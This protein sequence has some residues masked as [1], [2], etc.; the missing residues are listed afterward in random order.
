MA[1]VKVGKN[2]VILSAPVVSNAHDTVHEGYRIVPVNSAA[3][4]KVS[5]S[6]E[7]TVV[8][9]PGKLA[10]RSEQAKAITKAGPLTSHQATMA[11]TN[12]TGNMA[13]G[14]S[15]IALD[16]ARP[17]RS[18]S[19]PHS[20]SSFS[21]PR[22]TMSNEQVEQLQQEHVASGVRSIEQMSEYASKI[23]TSCGGIMS[24]MEQ[25]D[26]VRLL[27]YASN[28]CIANFLKMP[29]EYA[30]V[31]ALAVLHLIENGTTA[32]AKVNTTNPDSRFKIKPHEFSGFLSKNVNKLDK[33]LKGKPKNSYCDGSETDC[34]EILN[35][36]AKNTEGTMKLDAKGSDIINSVA[37]L[38][39][40]LALALN[41]DI[42]NLLKIKA[43]IN[44]FRDYRDRIERLANAHQ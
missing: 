8:N 5:T 4:P 37:A 19:T 33:N 44:Q 36:I 40:L 35:K 10:I 1:D 16:A 12:I 34:F 38:D 20:S 25:C 29:D 22:G 2:S 14:S 43:Q 23:P 6:K 21:Y 41:S 31:Y 28:P 26:L 32:M 3:I 24:A 17:A 39:T 18:V 42:P 27:I 30:K 9:Y 13:K 15:L 7:L 11:L